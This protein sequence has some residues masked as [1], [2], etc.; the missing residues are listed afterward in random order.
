LAF[1]A[2]TGYP[3]WLTAAARA[4]DFVASFRDEAGGFVTSKAAEGKTG[5]LA[6][7]AR[8]IDDQVQVARFMN[9]LTR[10]FG[11]ENYR[12]QAAHAMRYL[13]SASA[14]MTR[15]LPGV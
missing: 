14:G 9:L 1:Q 10:Y 5:V 2:A 13:A 8:L 7:P 12:E 4:G 3:D 6:K 11:S 15:P